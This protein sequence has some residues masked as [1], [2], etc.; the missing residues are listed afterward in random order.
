MANSTDF[1]TLAGG[2]MYIDPYKDGKPSGKWQ[3][4]GLTTAPQVSIEIETLE[5][6]NTEGPTQAVDKTIVQK[7]SGFISWTSD[8]MSPAM[9]S[10]A[11]YGEVI[12]L[13]TTKTL[14]FTDLKAG[15]FINLDTTGGDL[16]AGALVEDEDYK[17]DAKRGMVEILK[18]TPEA[19]FS[20][21][22]ANVAQAVEAFRKTKLE[23]AL[24]FVGES[25]TG[26]AIKTE[27]FKCSIR[28][29]GE[30]ALKSDEWMSIGFSA[31]ILKDETKDPNLGSQ[32]FKL[33]L[34]GTN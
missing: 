10:R 6:I 34:L 16:D 3:Y 29:D 7:Q 27:F 28:Q 24:M 22:G 15:D 31:D 19:E 9:L 2:K 5:H 23:A 17:F 32:F 33:T 21:S 20:V 4:F 13:D 25:A 18:D 11:F 12:E 30:F 14:S 1:V 26:S 8:E